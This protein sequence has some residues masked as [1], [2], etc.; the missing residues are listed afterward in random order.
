M[1]ENMKKTSFSAVVELPHLSEPEEATVD[2]ELDKDEENLTYDE[3][4]DAVITK[5]CEENGYDEDFYADRDMFPQIVS[6]VVNADDGKSYPVLSESMDASELKASKEY[7]KYL[8][9]PEARYS[10]T[11]E[12]K[13]WMMLKDEGLI[14]EDAQ[15]DF[16]AYHELVTSMA[17]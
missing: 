15:F 13:L 4:E 1:E 17:K 5:A 6:L 11:P 9:L 8:V 10:L 12:A 7:D 16:D 14:G 2:V 3:V